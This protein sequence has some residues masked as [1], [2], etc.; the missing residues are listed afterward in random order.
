MYRDT[1]CGSTYSMS[2]NEARDKELLR[3]QLED[4]FVDNNC[5]S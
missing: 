5:K 2:V 1:W 4:L 3:T